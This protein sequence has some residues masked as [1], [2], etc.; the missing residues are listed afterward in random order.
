MRPNDKSLARSGA[1]SL[2]LGLAAFVLS[3][4]GAWQGWVNPHPLRDLRI[5]QVTVMQGRETPRAFRFLTGDERTVLLVTFSTDR[6]FDEHQYTLQTPV[7]GAFGLCRDGTVDAS[8]RLRAISHYVP[9]G[10][11]YLVGGTARQSPRQDGRFGYQFLLPVDPRGHGWLSGS[12]AHDVRLS[13][14]DL[15]VHYRGGEYRTL[16]VRIPY[17]MIAEAL[18]RAGQPHAPLP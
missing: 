2:A 11:R 15:C 14:E 3:A 10:R 1:I 7:R 4:C 17:R 8:R 13:S 5:E 6:D 9:T 16:D 18:S 12:I